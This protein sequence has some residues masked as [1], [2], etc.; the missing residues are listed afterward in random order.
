MAA[1]ALSENGLIL[2]PDLFELPLVQYPVPF[3]SLQ[4]VEQEGAQFLRPDLLVFFVE[5]FEF[6]QVVLVAQGVQAVVVGE[7]GVSNGRG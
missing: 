5:E 3:P 4:T 6:A 1:T 2:S 7:V